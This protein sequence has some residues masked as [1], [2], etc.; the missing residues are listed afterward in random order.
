MA[1]S[2]CCAI[3]RIQNVVDS[4]YRR[5]FSKPVCRTSLRRV[6]TGASA[7]APLGALREIWDRR[8]QAASGLPLLQLGIALKSMGDAN[9]S[10]QALAL[11]LNTP[12]RDAQQWMADYGSALRD[13]AL[14]LA[15]L[16]ENKLKPDVQNTLLNT[17][18]EQAFGQ[19]WLSTQE[20]NA[21]FL[22]ARTLQDLLVRGRRKRHSRSN[23]WQGINR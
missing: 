9:R 7:K 23:H 14:M 15:L 21:L 6:G 10:E 8:A 19:R 16:E 1:T 11:A 20:N 2:G 22:A 17:L 13:N 3:C 12:R 18:S 5:L 4:L